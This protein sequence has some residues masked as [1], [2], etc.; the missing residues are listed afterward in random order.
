MKKILV[1]IAFGLI[2]EYLSAQNFEIGG[3]VSYGHAYYSSNIDLESLFSESAEN[4]LNIGIS[5]SSNPHKSVLFLNSGLF[6][7]RIYNQSYSLN[8]LKVP[9]GI[10]LAFGNRLK[11]FFGG[12]AY[13]NWLFYAEGF[14]E[15]S[16]I[17]DII[18]GLYG[19]LGMRYLISPEWCIYLK[20]R[21][22]FDQ[23]PLFP[24][25]NAGEHFYNYAVAIG[26][27]YLIP[28]KNKKDS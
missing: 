13:I 10:D 22:E 11:F 3:E 20:T 15:P 14:Q 16:E 26:F 28:S 5:A 4:N 7:N 2:T 23:V 18:V 12:G 24:N 6:Y 25:D 8:F 17:R 21:M 1:I 9:A 27:K 19:D